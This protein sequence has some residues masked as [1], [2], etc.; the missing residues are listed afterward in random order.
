MTDLELLNELK[1]YMKLSKDKDKLIITKV[2]KGSYKKVGDTVGGYHR[3]GY[4]HFQFNGK[5]LIVHR[6]IWLFVYKKLPKQG[7]DHI[8]GIKDDNKIS[9]LRDVSQGANSRNQAKRKCYMDTPIGVTYMKRSGKFS[10]RVVSKGVSYY[11]GEFKTVEEADNACKQKRKQLG[12][13][14]INHGRR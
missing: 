6:I 9:N 2:K 10:A 4:L 5:M 14:H 8:N 7:I 3:E 1:K 12:T 13:F 11:L